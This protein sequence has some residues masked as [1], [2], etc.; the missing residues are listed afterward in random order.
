[1]RQRFFVRGMDCAHE[2]ALLRKELGGL[3]GVDDL[4]FDVTR[5]RMTVVG[6]VE[7]SAIEA[8]VLRTG[9][10]ASPWTGHEREDRSL[11]LLSTAVSGLAALAGILAGAF[12]GN[13]TGFFAVAVGAGIWHVVPRAIGSARRLQPDMHLLMTIAIA[14]AIGIGVWFEAASVACLY[15]LSLA[16]EAWS[17]GRARRAVEALLEL[18]PA[19]ATLADDE[20][21][22][23]AEE[24]AVGNRI[25]VRPGERV[26]LDGIIV[27]G[28]FS[29]AES[30]RPYP[31]TA[32]RSLTRSLSC[33]LPSTTG[34]FAL[35]I[36]I[37]V[38]PN[39]AA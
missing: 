32:S 28:T 7:A 29:R 1:M 14:G 39:W 22:V 38:T 36:T 27:N 6:A 23:P 24:V 10:R 5:Q 8:A 26:P 35:F 11:L 2:T 13:T 12:G 30:L 15:S 17:V 33:Q 4:S 37:S 25:L 20:R 34:R 19:T 3:D 16:L 9:M 21:V 18:A 31:S